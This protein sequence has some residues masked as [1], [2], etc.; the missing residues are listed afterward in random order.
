MPAVA[1]QVYSCEHGGFFQRCCPIAEKEVLGWLC[2]ICRSEKIA[3]DV[4]SVP[5][6]D[7][8]ENM[9]FDCL[10][11]PLG[12]RTHA[13]TIPVAQESVHTAKKLLWWE[14]GNV[15]LLVADRCCL[16]VKTMRDSTAKK[17]R[18]A[19]VLICVSNLIETFSN[20]G[21]CRSQAFLKTK[22]M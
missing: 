1:L 7:G 21:K 17:Q 16:V 8:F 18:L 14:A 22:M 11:Q 12:S 9:L 19:A 5:M 13:R 3:M 15:S 2:R 6:P 20:H 10:L 4:W